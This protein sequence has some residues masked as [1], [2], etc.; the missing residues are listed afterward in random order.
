M[1]S[2]EAPR[3][4]RRLVF[5]IAISALQGCSVF[6]QLVRHRDPLTAE[7]HVQL[8]NAY[9]EQALHEK[10]IDQYQAALRLQENNPGAL[11]NLAMVYLVSGKNLSQA[12]RWARR[13]LKEG[14]PLKPYI[15]DTLASIDIRQNRFPEAQK[16]LD[17]AL[18]VAP[19]NNR[20]LR[21][22]LAKTRLGISPTPAPVLP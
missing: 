9:E 15:L 22:Q 7:E 3:W 1:K 20:P 5:F 10:A 4:T 12:E 18:A 13:A 14:G 21:E 17:D 11:N 6:P 16:A 19:A 8:G 2:P